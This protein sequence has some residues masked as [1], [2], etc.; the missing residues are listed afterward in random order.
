MRMYVC[1]YQVEIP[2]TWWADHLWGRISAQVHNTLDQ[3]QKL[4]DA[5]CELQQPPD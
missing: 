5:I 3:Y 4:A 2:I 1:R